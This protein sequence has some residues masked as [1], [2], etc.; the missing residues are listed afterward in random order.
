MQSGLIESPSHDIATT[1]NQFP[2]TTTAQHGPGRFH[3]GLPGAGSQLPASGASADEQRFGPVSAA[4][5]S[6]DDDFNVSH[7]DHSLGRLSVVTE[8]QFSALTR[9][10]VAGQRIFDYE[11]AAISSP[12]GNNNSHPGLGLKV[13]PNP[14]LSSV[15]LTDFPNGSFA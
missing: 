10:T 8:G 15:Y 13:S 5:G 4:A 6:P 11:N 7:L 9:A 1:D 12:L 3:S 14:K 2:Q